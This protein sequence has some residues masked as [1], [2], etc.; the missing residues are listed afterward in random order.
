MKRLL[1]NIF[2]IAVAGLLY[3]CK[4]DFNIQAEFR[5]R[6]ILTC[7]IRP[8]TSFQVVTLSSSYEIEG[9]NPYSNTETPSILG[10]DVKMWYNNQVYQFR[11][12]TIDRIDTSRYSTP[13]T[14]YYN[15]DLKP[16]GGRFVDLEALLPNGLL[17]TSE[18]QVPDLE[19]MS[20]VLSDTLVPPLGYRQEVELNWTKMG[21]LVY[22]PQFI[23]IY[24]NRVDHQK[25]EK[26]IPLN[27]SESSGAYIPN[28]PK[29]SS[30]NS[31][32]FDM[33]VINRAMSEISEGDPV[34]SNYS[35]VEMK[36]K[37]MV[38]DKNLSA[39][40]SSVQQFLDGFT[41]KVDQ[42]D[43]TNVRGGFGVFG[44]I[45][46]KEYELKISGSYVESFGYIV[47]FGE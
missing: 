46:V 39:Y 43:F 37:V 25:Y 3:S 35:I 47:G 45:N 24:Y 44:S 7:I 19:S 15:N 4:E 8:D 16:I 21:E 6:N 20:F 10:A 11:D 5:P 41:V 14:F 38:Y 33:D 27:Y 22:H 9:L 26:E 18:T 2:L 42:P 34:K 17:L 32:V 30:R 13:I 40:Y 31:F 1:I 12:S 29:P 28:Y 23:I 36:L